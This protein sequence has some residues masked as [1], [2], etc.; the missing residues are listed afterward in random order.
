MCLHGIVRDDNFT[1]EQ[2]YDSNSN[3]A[4]TKYLNIF[5]YATEFDETIQS[6]LVVDNLC[7]DIQ[8]H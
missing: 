4:R 2:K 1:N 3:I 5:W 6:C 8:I 7:T